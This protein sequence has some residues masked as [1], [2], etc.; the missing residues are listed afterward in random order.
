MKG[1]RYTV[2]E[3]T[4]LAPV[5]DYYCNDVEMNDASICTKWRQVLGKQ[6]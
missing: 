5:P 3:S 2:L 6:T 1:F 4:E